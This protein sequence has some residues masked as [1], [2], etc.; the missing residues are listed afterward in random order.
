MATT[1]PSLTATNYNGPSR[2]WHSVDDDANNHVSAEKTTDTMRRLAT[3]DVSDSHG[4][5]SGRT[6]SCMTL[7]QLQGKLETT[8]SDQRTASFLA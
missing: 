8:L 3:A 4:T 5:G 1:V 7:T 2:L 6:Y